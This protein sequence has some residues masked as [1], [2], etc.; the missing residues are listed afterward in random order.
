MNGPCVTSPCDS[1]SSSGV[2]ATAAHIPTIWTAQATT[3]ALI[4]RQFPVY[5]SANARTPY[6]YTG[7][8]TAFTVF[9]PEKFQLFGRRD[10]DEKVEQLHE[11]IAAI[12][13]AKTTTTGRR[14]CRKYRPTAY[15]PI[16]SVRTKMIA[17]TGID[18]VTWYA[19]LMN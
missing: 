5:A 16:A 6:A 7:K 18:G 8:T 2:R 11:L 19:G 12:N 4:H 9:F 17:Y 10:V 15:R 3:T 13:T 1:Y 14:S